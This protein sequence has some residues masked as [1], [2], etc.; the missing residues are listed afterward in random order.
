MQHADA[1][2]VVF[3]NTVDGTNNLDVDVTRLEGKTVNEFTI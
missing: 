3:I 2:E 1:D